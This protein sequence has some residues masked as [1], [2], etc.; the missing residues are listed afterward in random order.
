M[1]VRAGTCVRVCVCVCV[2]DILVKCLLVHYSVAVL[3]IGSSRALTRIEFKL[4]HKVHVSSDTERLA[5]YIKT[6][7]RGEKQRFQV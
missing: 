3:P 5:M 4:S 7:W 2:C 6:L 1:C